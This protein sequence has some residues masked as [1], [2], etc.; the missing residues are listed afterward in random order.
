MKYNSLDK[1]DSHMI[2]PQKFMHSEGYVSNHQDEFHLRCGR[3]FLHDQKR[4][5]SFG[6]SKKEYFVAGG[7][8]SV[9]FISVGQ[10][11]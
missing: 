3:L 6:V 4:T 9:D 8:V 7:G 10:A 5:I 1:F 2:K 11:D